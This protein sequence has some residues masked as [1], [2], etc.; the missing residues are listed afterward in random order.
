MYTLTKLV[1]FYVY[2]ALCVSVCRSAHNSGI[3]SKFSGQLQGAR[4]W[5]S[6]QK[7]GVEVLGLRVGELADRRLGTRGRVEDNGEGCG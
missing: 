7:I 3:F 4:G 6:A 5:F 1:D 2:K